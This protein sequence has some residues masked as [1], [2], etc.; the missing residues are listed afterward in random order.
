M[1]TYHMGELRLS[2][3]ELNK[4]K[5]LMHRFGPI[6]D[7]NPTLGS[8]HEAHICQRCVCARAPCTHYYRMRHWSMPK[9]AKNLGLLRPG[10]KGPFTTGS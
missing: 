8:L 1:Y 2:L 4:V 7:P 10:V 5:P 9:I 3:V 6:Y